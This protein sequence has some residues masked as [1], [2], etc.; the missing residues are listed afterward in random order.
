MRKS[1]TFIASLLATFASGIHAQDAANV[2]IEELIVEGEFLE[3]T[4]PALAN[5]AVGSISSMLKRFNN[6]EHPTSPARSNTSH[7]VCF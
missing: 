4:P 1:Q 5:T 6:S 3:E 2:D 7:R